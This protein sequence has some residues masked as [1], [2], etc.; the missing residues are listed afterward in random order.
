MDIFLPILSISIPA[1]MHNKMF[2]RSIKVT[3]QDSC[4]EFSRTGVL[5]LDEYSNMGDDHPNVVPAMNKGRDTDNEEF[6][7]MIYFKPF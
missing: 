6:K 4:D 1:G 2:P 7:N 3:I 5:P